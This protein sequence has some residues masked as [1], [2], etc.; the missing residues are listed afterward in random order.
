MAGSV[1]PRLTAA[2][3]RRFAFTLAGAF[4]ALGALL[5]WRSRG[6]AAPY[7]SYASL[8]LAATLLAAGALIP[9]RLSPVQRAWMA[10][11]HLISR[12]TTPIFMAV[13]YFGVITPISLVMRLVGHNPLRR[14]A[15]EG[16]FWVVR[17]V[18]EQRTDI[19][20]QF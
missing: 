20:R 9:T 2:E 7:A 12:V 5:W 6:T 11:A 15:P 16:S 13:V 4:L 14:P 1:R 18:A 3:G 10:L 19:E 17:T 8:S